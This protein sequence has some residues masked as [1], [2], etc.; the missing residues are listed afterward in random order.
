MDRERCEE[1]IELGLPALRF[2]RSGDRRRME[3]FREAIDLVCAE[4][5]I[6]LEHAARFA[7]AFAR[8]RASTSLA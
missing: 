4:Y 7:G 3:P 2:N 5:G 8:V 6:G 1:G